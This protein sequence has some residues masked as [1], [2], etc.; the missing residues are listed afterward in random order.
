MAKGSVNLNNPIIKTIPRETFQHDTKNAMIR[1]AI[2]GLLGLIL[3]TFEETKSPIWLCGG[4][5]PI[6]LNELKNKNI[7]IHHYPNLVLEGMIYV[8]QNLNSI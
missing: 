4:D 1:G 3:Q 7:S 2:N 6:L 8:D 5:A